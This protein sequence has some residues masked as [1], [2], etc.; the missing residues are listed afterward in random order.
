[1]TIKDHV[2]GKVRF[3]HYRKGNLFYV[4][5]TCLTF[6][7]PIDDIG[8]ATFLDVDKAILFMRYIK[9]H[10]KDIE[11]AQLKVQST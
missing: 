3:S 8:D 7:V 11:T 5:E 1:M 10:L 4:T 9:K 2:K 6:P